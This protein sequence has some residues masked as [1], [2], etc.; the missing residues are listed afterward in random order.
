MSWGVLRDQPYGVVNEPMSRGRVVALL[1]HLPCQET[2]PDGVI[3]GV[4]WAKV[5]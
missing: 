4:N 5:T 3:G 2:N 1:Q